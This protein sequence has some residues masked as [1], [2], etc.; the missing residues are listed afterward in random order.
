MV[1]GQVQQP[2]LEKDLVMKVSG[3]LVKRVWVTA[4]SKLPRPAESERS[5]QRVAAEDA[6]LQLWPQEQLQ[7]L[8]LIPPTFF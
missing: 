3:P 7:G 1:H 8:L 4:L 2:Q 6:Q 5:L